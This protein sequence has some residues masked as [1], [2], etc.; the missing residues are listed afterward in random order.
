M[1]ER[2][3]NDLIDMMVAATSSSPLDTA[4]RAFWVEQLTHIEDADH[5]T[6]TILEGI[7]EWK[8]FPSWSDFA[9]LH[10]D[11]GRRA[12]A[13]RELAERNGEYEQAKAQPK[14]EVPLWVKRWVCATM[15]YE[16]FGKDRDDRRFPEMGSYA[17]VTLEAMPDDAWV[18]EAGQLSDAE[19]WRNL[20]PSSTGASTS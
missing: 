9:R 7:R 1:K 13:E 3:A 17:D 2:E 16:R 5:A 8:F 11:V 10:T 15:L 18:E 20:M 14:R 12:V 4:K 19:V 6:T